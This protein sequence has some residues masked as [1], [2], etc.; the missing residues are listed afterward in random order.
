MRFCSTD[1]PDKDSRSK[2]HQLHQT[3][4]RKLWT[5]EIRSCYLLVYVSFFILHSSWR[6]PLQIMQ[7]LTINFIHSLAT[8]YCLQRFDQPNSFFLSFLQR[9]V[10]RLYWKHDSCFYSDPCRVGDIR[11]SLSYLTK[12]ADNTLSKLNHARAKYV[13][14]TMITSATSR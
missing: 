8:Y 13:R 10:Y 9:P 11:S 7:A 3:D 2:T 4:K 14:S 1:L 5:I 6:T 12:R